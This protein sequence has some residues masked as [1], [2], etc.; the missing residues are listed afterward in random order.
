MK[1]LTVGVKPAVFS[2]DAQPASY[3]TD[4]NNYIIDFGCVRVLHKCN[5]V[6][7]SLYW[8]TLR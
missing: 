4:R 7:I 1:R 3:D 2:T 5:R 6:S 8:F